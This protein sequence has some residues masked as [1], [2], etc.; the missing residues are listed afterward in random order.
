[1]RPHLGSITKDPNVVDDDDIVPKRSACLAAKSKFR[2]PKLE[3]QAR[4]VLM[5]KIGLLIETMK[6]DESSFEE[7]QR[8]FKGPL[9]PSKR[10]AMRVLF[11]M[12]HRRR[13]GSVTN[14][15]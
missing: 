5:K 10:E 1:L 8:T 11:P 9:S 12:R 14:V 2:E 13:H 7:F 4:K 15:E 6:P 3:A